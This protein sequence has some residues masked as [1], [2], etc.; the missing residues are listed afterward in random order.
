[1]KGD[2]NRRGYYPFGLTMAGISS[3]A[4]GIAPNKDKTFQGQ[5][6]DDDL[7]I[8][9]DQFKWRNHDPQIGRF[10]EIDPLASEY[11]YNSTYAFSEN[12]VTG[13]IEL[14]GLEKVPATY[15]DKF[16]R[17]MDRKLIESGKLDPHVYNA[18][19]ERFTM[20]VLVALA[21]D[22]GVAALF[23]GGSLIIKALTKSEKVVETTVQ[24]VE[25]VQ[26]AMSKAEL[27][28]TETEGLVRGGREGTHH[29]S[30][31]IGND[32][33][34]VRQRLALPQTPEVKATMEVPKGSFSNPT[35]VEA[36]NKMPGGG[37]ERK[38][39]GNIPAKVI[40]VQEL[41]N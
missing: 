22:V 41:K 31:A 3:K 24:E 34:K 30:D 28:A 32:A 12:Q 5:K 6:F 26:R 39:T 37:L 27:K 10:I 25:V 40:K 4:T 36:A 17:Q 19:F 23:K 21:T 13:H 8:N 18:S 15:G 35:K 16:E 14:E 33:N 2:L 20:P 11:E 9:Y 29:V 38:A 1:M 7:E